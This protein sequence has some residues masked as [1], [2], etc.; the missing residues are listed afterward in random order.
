[1]ATIISQNTTWR[2]GE[3]VNLTAEVQ[4]ANGVTL[5]VEPGVTINGNG[6]TIKVFGT[7][8]VSGSS[9][10]HVVSNN[11][12]YTLSSNSQT[13]GNIQ[14]NY[15]DL[16]GGAFLAPSGNAQY[17]K[18][19]VTNSNFIGVSGFYLWYPTA[20]STF[21]GNT[22]KQ[23]S[24]LSIGTNQSGTV[25]VKNNLFVNQTTSFAVE[26]WA[27]YNSGILVDSNSFISTDRV[28]LAL[29]ENYSSAALT[30][31]NNY[32]GTNDI[33]VINSMIVD[34]NDSLTYASFISNSYT[35]TPN[36]LTPIIVNNAPVGT[37]VISGAFNQ[38]GLV[39]ATNNISDID[40]MGTVSYKWQSSTNQITWTDTDTTN[41]VS[42]LLIGKYLRACAVFTDN[43]GNL[44][45]VPSA[46]VLV[47][48][49]NSPASGS[50]YIDGT[51]RQGE[52]LVVAQG[53]VFDLD[54]TGS[55]SYKW[56]SSSDGTS[57]SDIGA[58]GTLALTATQVGKV[59]RVIAS[60]VDGRGTTES[61]YSSTTV[62][63][64]GLNKLP[65]GT[66]TISGA[67]NPGETVTASN[68]LADADGI[69]S[70]TYQWQSSTDLINWSLVTTGSSLSLT[71]VLIGKF[72]RVKAS[73]TDTLG[74][75]E[76][77]NANGAQVLFANRPPTGSV[78]LSGIAKQGETLV[79]TNTLT[80]VDGLTP[81]LY[82]WKS[83]S[84]GV[85]WTTI[86]NGSSLNVGESLVGKYIQVFATYVDGKG[87][88]E[89]IGSS[90]SS[91]VINVNDLPTGSVAINGTIKRGETVTAS[92]TIGDPDGIGTI[93]YKWQSS[94]DLINWSDVSTG[95]SLTIADAQVGKYLRVNATFTDGRGTIESVSSSAS[96]KVL[97]TNHPPTGSLSII[98]SVKQG[99]VVLVISTLADSDG[100]GALTYKWQSSSDNI[101]W[102]EFSTGSVHI[103]SSSQLGKLVR[104]TASYVDGK[105]TSESV[106][107]TPIGTITNN[108]PT[109]VV[110][111]IGSAT[112][113][114]TLTATNNLVD[115]DGLG[116]ITYKW[117][118]STDNTAWSDLSTGSTLSISATNVGKYLRV[119]ASYVDR[120][121]TIESVTSSTTS[122][123]KPISST[124]TESHVLSVI[125][126]T[127]VLGLSP[128][129]LKDLTETM[130][131]INGVVDKH[132]VKYAGS[133]FNYNQIQ[134]LITPV[135]RDNEFTS[136]FNREINDYLQVE[137]NITYKAAV[138]LVGLTNMDSVILMIAGSDGNFVG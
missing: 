77:V 118:T 120:I 94:S 82:V 50:V 28:A 39:S 17:G 22:F 107:S 68:N 106:S 24:G 99:D 80:D 7:L 4:I 81:I 100:L 85:T 79:V 64:K 30:A 60:F 11:V 121:G 71:D 73:Y 125:V 40:G 33:S 97:F 27:N 91:M 131:L 15:I 127:G 88:I 123:V 12:N 29:P 132:T 89:S 25:L 102:T 52:V 87:T 103:I 115:F 126:N 108:P 111:I 76:S 34:K 26:S 59:I 43:L 36:V 32:F 35:S 8:N 58:G 101:N 14:F 138:A 93:S 109:G 117:Q 41:G 110:S 2:R 44:E 3:T 6:N 1:M 45:S 129:F 124:K 31:T 116:S 69:G 37:V 63:I 53:S 114:E 133:E 66:V 67:F 65:T 55:I 16:K 128:V 96:D 112:Q 13:V 130:T 9:S 5:T 62:A 134:N 49:L 135:L 19:D 72:V 38:G 23:S 10:S 46:S 78:T 90:R 57:W 136:Q 21:I 42:V 48:Y 122:L 70:I 51:L 137:L 75:A 84:E 104:V 74:T 105:G 54:G 92:N 61:F 20:P 47:T 86:A 83:S 95:V 98:G 56:Q 18:Y 119:N 113:G